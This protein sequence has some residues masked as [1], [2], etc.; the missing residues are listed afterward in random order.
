MSEKR[1]LII[2]DEP[3]MVKMASDQLKDAGFEVI[4]STNP[5]DGVQLAKS[6][7]PDLILLDIRMP[8]ID[9]FEV[10]RRLKAVE[11]T[12]SIP[13]IIV[14]IQNEESD[15]VLGLGLGA[16]DY[17]TKPYR[18]AELLA[19]IK[20]ALRDQQPVEEKKSLKIG[21]I[22]ADVA[23][24][25][26]KVNGRALDLSP[27]EFLLLVLFMRREGQVLTR[28]VISQNIWNIDHMPTSM[29]I[30]THVKTL[31]K[32]LGEAGNSI[33]A[34]KGVGYRFEVDE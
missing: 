33:Q 31:R 8:K 30:N 29:T 5:F 27:K 1:I 7:H 19:R 13:I 20:T 18:K 21:P 34:L 16:S 9:G 26:A 22:E 10:C 14:S 2:D 15:V 32:K 25:I 3:A 28:Q 12:A 17:V 4:A 23:T 6:D 11:E 24:H